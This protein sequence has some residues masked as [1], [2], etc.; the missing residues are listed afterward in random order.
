MKKY[1]IPVL[2]SLLISV[3]SWSQTITE[4]EL[5]TAAKNFLYERIN[6]KQHIEYKDLVPDSPETFKEFSH[7]RI[8]NFT[9]SAYIILSSKKSTLP[10]IGY[11]LKGHFSGN[12][13]PPQLLSYLKKV[14]LQIENAELIKPKKRDL[15]KKEWEHLLSLDHKDIKPFRGRETDPLLHTKWDQG[16]YYNGKCPEDP[17]GP[18]GRCYAGCV[19]TAMGQVMNYFR[20]PLTGIGSYSYQCPPYG[21]LSANF[22]ITNYLWNDMPLYLETSNDAVAILLHHLGVS[23]DMVYGPNGSGMYNHKAAYSLRTFFK[24]GPE[25]QYVYRDSTGMDWDSLLTD[26]LDKNIPMYYAGWSVPNIN[27]HAFVCDGYQD[28][29]YYHFNWGWSGSY[30]GYFYTDNLTPGGSNFNLAQEVIINAFPDTSTYV[31]PYFCGSPD[32]IPTYAGTIDD[33]SGPLYN[34]QENLSCNWLIAPKDSVSSISLSFL[35]FDLESQDTLFIYNGSSSEF[36]LIGKYTGNELP[37]DI[38][39]ENDTAFMEFITNSSGNS[40]GWLLSYTSEIPVYC[41]GL[42]MLT[43]STDTISDGSGPRNYHNETTCL[44]NIKPPDASGITLY[45]T[46]FN[47]EDTN[48]VLK[49]YDGSQLIAELSGNELPEPLVANSG[50]MFLTFSTNMTITAPGWEAYYVADYVGIENQLTDPVVSVFPNPAT[51]NLYIE[52]SIVMNNCNVLIRNIRNEIIYAEDMN[53]LTKGERFEIDISSLSQGI[54][55]LTLGDDKVMHH[56]KFVKTD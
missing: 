32:T 21:Q 14:S 39:T 48:D 36:P 20:W 33:G 29:Y 46:S 42:S 8:I 54:Y 44:W 22:G 45:F 19:A 49:V 43:E 2:F 30:D 3:S 6:S 23:V 9:P 47:T 26:H 34:Y 37:D 56:H 17:Q 50:S 15:F 27:G 4:N 28:P 41:S 24:Y 18:G 5:I 51:D 25:T 55:F 1:L 7:L 40:E 10:V 35:T 13:I 16:V 38:T 52:T 53:H 12:D 11:S 31:Y